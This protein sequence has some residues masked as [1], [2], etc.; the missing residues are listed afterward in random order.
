MSKLLRR[1]LEFDAHHRVAVALVVAA[2]VFG[3]SF[4]RVLF[5]ASLILAWD[6]FA[7]CSL[8]IAWAGIFFTDARTRVQEAHLQDSGRAAICCCVSL[9]A[10]A[11]LFGAVLLLDSAKSLAAEEARW[12]VPLAAATVI[13]SWLLVHTMLTLH[14]AHVCYRIAAKSKEKPPNLGVVFPDEPQPD[15]LDFAYFSFVI[16]MTCQVSDVQITSRRVRRI[17]LVHGLLSFGFNTV[18]LALGLNLASGLL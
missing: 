18:I 10:I 6:A 1:L 5:P 2:L 9:A 7:I 17:A 16:G 8:A 14:Y 3:I 15:F 13:S 12:I 11:G 4:R